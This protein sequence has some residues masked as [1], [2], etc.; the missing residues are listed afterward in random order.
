MFLLKDKR[1]EA[2]QIQISK[3]VDSINGFWGICMPAS[4]DNLKDIDTSYRD[5]VTYKFISPEEGIT[6]SSSLFMMKLLFT[7]LKFTLN[8]SRNEPYFIY[9]QIKLR[10]LLD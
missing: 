10:E 6:L 4:V 1:S 7:L 8:Q 2:W 5:F 9:G 3:I